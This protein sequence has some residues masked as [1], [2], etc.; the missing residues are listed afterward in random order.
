ML[1]VGLTPPPPRHT[2][3]LPPYTQT[4]HIK[5]L[6]TWLRRHYVSVPRCEEAPLG[7]ALHNLSTVL[8][9]PSAALHN[10]STA[11]HHLL[12]NPS[13]ALHNGPSTALHNSPTL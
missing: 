4:C 1:Q 3:Q 11:L 7:A 9:N 10:L 2:S 12:R 8:H 5:V 13:T 6:V